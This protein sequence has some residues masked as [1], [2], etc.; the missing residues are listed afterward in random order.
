MSTPLKAYT[1][2]KQLLHQANSPLICFLEACSPALGR[3]PSSNLGLHNYGSRHCL[4]AL[5]D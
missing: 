5:A 1:K 2:P 3:M 4:H